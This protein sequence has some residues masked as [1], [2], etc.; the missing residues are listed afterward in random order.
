MASTRSQPLLP[1]AQ[2][3]WKERQL[4]IRVGYPVANC[5]RPHSISG[6]WEHMTPGDG[7]LR[8]LPLWLAAI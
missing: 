1:V 8:S 4:V 3:G 5:N 6:S 7:V 2:G